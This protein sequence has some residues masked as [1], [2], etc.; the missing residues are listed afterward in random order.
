MTSR[1]SP[2]I[3]R[4]RLD[5]APAQFHF[6]QIQ[7]WLAC[8]SNG[9]EKVQL[10]FRPTKK[11]SMLFSDLIQVRTSGRSMWRMRTSPSAD[12]GGREGARNGRRLAKEEGSLQAGKVARPLSHPH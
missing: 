2:L 1:F 9:A 8:L 12:G 4:V 6:D 7:Q 11:L 3:L 5:T 10:L